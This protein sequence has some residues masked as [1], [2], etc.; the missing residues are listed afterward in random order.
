MRVGGLGGVVGLWG[1]VVVVV[2]GDRD[3]GK[4]E[5]ERDGYEWSKYT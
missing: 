3:I 4:R 2:G 1:L 5:R